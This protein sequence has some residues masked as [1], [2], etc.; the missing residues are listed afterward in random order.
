MS[1]MGGFSLLCPLSVVLLYSTRLIA[2]KNPFYH[3][4]RNLDTFKLHKFHVTLVTNTNPPPVG[5]LPTNLMAVQEGITS[6]LVSWTPP[7]PPGHTTGYRVCYISKSN[8]N[9]SE[10]GNVSTESYFLTGLTNGEQYSITV[11]AMSK[12]LPGGNSDVVAVSLGEFVK[13]Q[14]TCMN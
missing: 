9:C 10:V 14:V 5:T 2:V 13:T 8:N 11:H 1:F 3:S 6:I 4:S 7:S 12:H